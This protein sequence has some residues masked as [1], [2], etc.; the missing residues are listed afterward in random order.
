MGGEDGAAHG[1]G[2]GLTASATAALRLVLASALAGGLV[3]LVDVFA[4]L[5]GGLDV[6]SC[7][8]FLVLVAFAALA[9]GWSLA[10]LRGLVGWLAAR[11]PRLPPAL[12]PTLLVMAAAI[13]L[14]RALFSGPGVSRTTL[15]RVGPYGFPV[16]AGLAALATFVWLARTSA[17]S[18][19]GRAL[20]LV[21]L[22]LAAL[23][24]LVLERLVLVGL[25]TYL[26]VLA[27]LFA[28]TCLA[29]AIELVLRERPWHAQVAAVVSCVVVLAFV[30]LSRVFPQHN[31]ARAFL[32]ERHPFAE[33]VMAGLGALF[34]FDGDGGS[35]LFVGG[36]C[37]DFDPAVGRHALDIPNNLLDEDCD[38]M[39]AAPVPAR[40]SY[41][42]DQVV[43]HALSSV[44]RTRPTVVIVIDALRADRVGRAEFPNLA[45]LAT[46]TAYFA[47]AYASASST[48]RSVPG[49]ITGLP[50][51]T[52]DDVSALEVM[53]SKGL[54]TALVTVDIVAD[55]VTGKVKTP[56]TL[57]YPMLRG[58]SRV[59]LVRTGHDAEKSWGGGI[60]A[61]TDARVTERAFAVLD[62]K[63]PP[64]LT[65]V[66]YFDLHQWMMLEPIREQGF[67]RYDAALR[68][69]DQELG[70]WL[71][72][73]DAL[74]LV[75]VSDHGE[76]LGEHGTPAHTQFLWSSLVRVPLLLS[77]PGVAPQRI[78]TAV[79]LVDLAP[80]ILSLVGLS[81]APQ[82]DYDLL[83]LI[84]SAQHDTSEFAAYETRQVSLLEGH[85]RV[86]F[87]LKTRATWLYDTA[88]DPEEHHSLI[89]QYPARA[90]RMIERAMA[91][92][93]R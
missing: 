79:T 76:A 32:V 93:V 46:H 91:L 49:M 5:W 50:L 78:T 6:L 1:A 43:A 90:Q 17:G 25:Y 11:S 88:L 69:V 59:E 87:D 13:P 70:R 52:P 65:W 66:H 86:I 18:T 45:Q 9:M 54:E 30:V 15:G 37:D 42:G 51:P 58:F 72:R 71:A 4:G 35:L 3:G 26:H 75:F 57:R 34:D 38:G 63:D 80:T 73:K 56:G 55:T 48:A 33:R 27:L 83:T 22:A 85:Y 62:G 36:D 47:N 92:R 82:S 8:G 60:T 44:T 41:G 84:G 14:G 2:D 24:A 21:I 68:R 29:L 67:A 20:R 40:R 74:N 64:A 89:E 77:V 16:L 31:A 39:D 61:S 7:M 12:V 53:R 10:C 28:L 19:R 81:A 23:L